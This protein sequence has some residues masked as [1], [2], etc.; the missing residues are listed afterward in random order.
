MHYLL[1]ILHLILV[2]VAGGIA[3]WRAAQAFDDR[4]WLGLFVIG[5]LWAATYLL[6]DWTLP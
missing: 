3:G 1:E 6:L 5:A 2:G 4:D